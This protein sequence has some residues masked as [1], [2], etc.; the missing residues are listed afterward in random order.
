MS[1]MLLAETAVLMHL[2]TIGIVLL[3]LDGVVIALLAILAGE[4]NLNALIR[5]HCRHLL[6][7]VWVFKHEY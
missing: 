7:E 2:Q 1:G 5:C 4:R 3:V 6:Y